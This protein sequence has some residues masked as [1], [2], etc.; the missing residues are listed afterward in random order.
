MGPTLRGGESAVSDRL[1]SSANDGNNPAPVQ[2]RAGV[3]DALLTVPTATSTPASPTTAGPT[4]AAAAPPV[5]IG[6]VVL[7]V[8]LALGVTAMSLMQSIVVPILGAIGVQLGASPEA[9]G[10]VLTANLLAAAVFTPVLGRLGDVYGERPVM[11]AILAVIAGAT[12]LA[13]LTSSLPLL[14]LARVL[15]GS[16]YGL[17]PLSVSVL[18]RE[19]PRE[20]LPVAMSVVSSTLAV[21]GVIGIVATGALSG[22]GGD[23]HPPFWLALA[24]AVAAFAAVHRFLP[25]RPPTATGGVDW[26]GALGL[27]VGLVLLLL[28]LSQA[29]SWGWTSVRTLGCLAAATVVLAGWVVLQRHTA[30]PLV[31]PA[32]LTDRRIVVPNIAGLMIGFGLFTSFLAVTTFVEVDPARA[33]YGFGASTWEAAVVF[34]LPGGI[35]GIALSPLAGQVVAR[36]GALWVM[37]AGGVSALAGFALFTLARDEVWQVVLF[38]VLLQLAVVVAFAALPALVVDAVEPGETGVANAVN[39]ICRS[40]GIA[41]ASAVIVTVVAGSYDP[42]TGAPTALAFTVVGVLGVASSVVVVVV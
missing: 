19:L 7:I 14:L 35:V 25:A 37:L 31:R 40:V 4:T 18:R 24:F 28:P 26:F 6:P 36:F 34:L 20:R 27:G 38:G 11:L 41:L 1:V 5:R 15:Q 10:W 12:L 17:F 32:L 2:L 3:P 9:A 16:A 33:G 23:Y 22:S 30:Q 21:G 42:A 13:A 29:A 39:S 8:T